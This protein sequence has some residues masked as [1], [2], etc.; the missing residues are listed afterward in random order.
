MELILCRTDDEQ[1]TNEYVRVTMRFVWLIWLT[2]LSLVSCTKNELCDV[3]A[4]TEALLVATPGERVLLGACRIENAALNVPQGVILEGTIK[5]DFERTVLVGNG[6]AAVIN[7]E[8]RSSLRNLGIEVPS[9]TGIRSVA[10]SIQIQNIE[11]HLTR[12]IGIG[13]RGNATIRDV[14]IDGPNDVER[15]IPFATPQEGAYGFVFLEGDVELQNVHLSDVGPWGGL[16]IDSMLR[17]TEGTIEHAVGTGLYTER[18]QVELHDLS[19]ETILRGLQPLPAYGAAFLENSEATTNGLNV[20]Q[21]EGVGILHERSSGEHITITANENRYGGVWIQQSDN[22]VLETP[23]F[24]QNG[25][26]A[27]SAVSSSNVRIEEGEISASVLA[28]SILGEIR[29]VESGDGIQII[30][31]RGTIE[32]RGTRLEDHPRIGILADLAEAPLSFLQLVDVRVDGDQLGCLAQNTDGLIPLGGWDD[33][34]I[35]SGEISANDASRR[36]IVPSVGSLDGSNLPQLDERGF[37]F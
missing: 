18:S 17:W 25:I 6:E 22:V 15:L 13:L 24:H 28:L 16:V 21:S 1:S 19:V 31:P 10:D 37:E 20:S 36:D 9:A 7:L 23:T 27:I 33:R 12:G 3:E 14:R 26:A 32:V 11:I 5:S 8:A 4:I 34:V 30:N 35:R 29:S 2:C